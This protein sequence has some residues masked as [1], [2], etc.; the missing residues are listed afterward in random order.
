MPRELFAQPSTEP[1]SGVES[2]P[3]RDVVTGKPPEQGTTVS[4]GYDGIQLA[5]LFVAEDTHPV[6]TLREH[7]APLY[8]EE[9]VELFIDPVGDLQSYFEIEVNPLNTTLDLVVR[10]NR[11]GLLKDLA[12]EC[13][14]LQTAV[15]LDRGKWITELRIPL[16]SIAPD[17]VRAGTQW[18]V[19]FC[20]IDRPAGRERELSAW[21][22]TGRPN[23]H[24]P[25]RFG[26]LKF[27]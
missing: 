7:D 20:R 21:S 14:G 13:V 1:W 4:I 17:P 5:V 16:D 2:V 12:W 22:Q 27:A 15:R 6:A 10:R 26:V 3:L 9:V 8:T 25:E 11:S 24:T 19:N 18:R 23:F